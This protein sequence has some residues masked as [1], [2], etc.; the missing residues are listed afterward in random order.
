MQKAAMLFN[1]YGCQAVVGLLEK[2]LNG[3]WKYIDIKGLTCKV[4]I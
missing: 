3:Q 1:L 2:A 4:N